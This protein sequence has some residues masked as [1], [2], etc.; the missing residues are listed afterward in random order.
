ML[1]STL[2]PAIPLLVPY[3]LESF[4][5]VTRLDYGSGH[6]LCFALFLMGLT[7][8]RFFESNPAEERQLV[9]VVFLRYLRL[10][11]RLQDVYRLEPAG[12]HG[13]WGIDDY[14]FLG[15]LWGSSQLRGRFYVW[16]G[17]HLLTVN[18]S[19]HISTCGHSEA[20]P[21]F[22]GPIQFVRL[23]DLR[24]ENRP[25]LRT[26][27][28]AFLDCHLGAVLGESQFGDGE[29]VRRGGLGKA[30]RGSAHTIGRAGCVGR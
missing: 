17:R 6:E 24:T 15:F 30:G 7:L 25:L 2:T 29:D 23:T 1:P 19:P 13:V 18:R 9:L 14:H 27:R 5:N 26:F 21:T 16:P 4:G 11:W 3:L 12:S 8:I 20:S 10:V 22:H 28:P